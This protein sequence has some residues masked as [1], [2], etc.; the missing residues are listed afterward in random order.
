MAVLATVGRSRILGARLCQ[1]LVLIGAFG[2]KPGLSGSV[3]VGRSLTLSARFRLV[4]FSRG[5]ALASLCLTKL[6]QE[7]LL[8]SECCHIV[9]IAIA[10][11]TVHIVVVAIAIE[12]IRLLAVP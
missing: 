10:I 6:H 3:A 2:A 4:N 1:P 5:V 11:A 7:E 12:V 9:V 8:E